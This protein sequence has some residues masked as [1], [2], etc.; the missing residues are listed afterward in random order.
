MY[1]HTAIH[2][3][4]RNSGRAMILFGLSGE[5]DNIISSQNSS[6]F[7]LLLEGI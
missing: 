4:Y 6:G 2:R 1:C 7:H 5:S 3:L